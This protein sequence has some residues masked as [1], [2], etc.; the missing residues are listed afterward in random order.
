[1]YNYVYLIQSVLY[2]HLLNCPSMTLNLFNKSR[3]GVWQ[4]HLYPG[5]MCDVIENILLHI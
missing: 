5:L 3:V 2:L 4:V 1:M